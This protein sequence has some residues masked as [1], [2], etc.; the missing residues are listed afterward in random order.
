MVMAPNVHGYAVGTL[1]G[2]LRKGT[3]KVVSIGLFVVSVDFDN[4]EKETF[5]KAGLKSGML[6]ITYDGDDTDWGHLGPSKAKD[7]APA[8]ADGKRDY[9]ALWKAAI[10][11]ASRLGSD[12]ARATSQHPPP[13]PPPP[14]ARPP[15]A[16]PRRPTPLRRLAITGTACAQ[17]RSLFI[18]S[19]CCRKA[20]LQAC[21]TA[22]DSTSPR[23]FSAPRSSSETISRAS[24]KPR[25]TPRP[26][27]VWANLAAR[28]AN[29]AHPAPVC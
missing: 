2:H 17:P 19:R 24:Q 9:K 10:T 18:A 23:A 27:A 7:E 25:Q 3:G 4:G 11:K 16:A 8:A 1:V 14:P 20:A 21:E 6:H 12:R 26:A 5:D 28:S 29:S 15:P 22:S 13:P